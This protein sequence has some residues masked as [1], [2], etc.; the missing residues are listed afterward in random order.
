VI[1]ETPIYESDHEPVSLSSTEESETLDEAAGRAELVGV[2]DEGK[3]VKESEGTKV[4]ESVNPIESVSVAEESSGGED[5]KEWEGTK[6]SES[7]NL[8]EP[9]RVAD[10]PN[11][12]EAVKGLEGTK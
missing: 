8:S 10:E 3:D 11:E 7:V 2:G 6:V 4:R 1:V 9:D 5:V 12:G